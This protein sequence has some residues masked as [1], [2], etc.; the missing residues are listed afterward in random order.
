MIGFVVRRLVSALLVVTLTSMITFALFFLGPTNP[1]APVC[2][3]SGRCTPER[4]QAIEQQMGFDESVVTQYGEFVKGLFAGRT[5]DFGAE[6]D[7]SAPCLGISY[8]TRNE[9]TEELM[10]RF[11]ATLSLALGA[12]AIYLVLGVV[13]GSLAARYRGTVTDRTLVGG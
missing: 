13:L 6:Y 10:N 12:A 8:G 11:P 5:V 4:L 3:A 7:C 2:E 9:V 1:A